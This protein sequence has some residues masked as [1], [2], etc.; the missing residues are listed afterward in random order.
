[1]ISDTSGK[2]AAASRGALIFAA[3]WSVYCTLYAGRH[4]SSVLLVALF[5]VWVVSP[6]AG[7]ALLIRS[8]SRQHIGIVRALQANSIVITLTSVVIYSAVAFSQPTHHTAFAF[9]AVPTA[10]WLAIGTFTA[11]TK[12]ARRP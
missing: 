8:A 12:F 2:L 7:F 4:N 6:F 10:T 9:L 11:A 3:I 5:V 1:M